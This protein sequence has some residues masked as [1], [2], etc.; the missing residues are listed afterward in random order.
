MRQSRL[1]LASAKSAARNS[2]L[3]AHV[4]ELFLLGAQTSF[5]VAQTLSVGQ[6]SEGHAEV[7]VETRKAFDLV[8]SSIARDATAKRRAR[9]MLGGTC[10]NTNLLKFMDAPYE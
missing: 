4:V 2:A 10:A 9:Q 8:S 6:L 7:L 1:S 5:D 3:D